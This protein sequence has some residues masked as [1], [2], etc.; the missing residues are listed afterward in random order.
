MVVSFFKYDEFP[1]TYSSFAG[2]CIVFIPEFLKSSRYKIAI[3]SEKVIFF[4]DSE[5]VK[6]LLAIFFTVFG[7]L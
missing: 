5:F 7:I 2:R 4:N 3:L 6:A 1:A